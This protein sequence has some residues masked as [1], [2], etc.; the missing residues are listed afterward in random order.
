MSKLGFPEA[1]GQCSPGDLAFPVAVLL[2]QRQVSPGPACT[3]DVGVATGPVKQ[4]QNTHGAER[5]GSCSDQGK[6]VT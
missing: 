2:L 3:V 5:K 6:A 1:V 4:C